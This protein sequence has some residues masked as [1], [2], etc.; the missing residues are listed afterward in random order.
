MRIVPF[1]AGLLFPAAAFAHDY[2]VGDLV[3]VHPMAYETPVTAQSGAGYMKITNNGAQ[4]DRLIAVEA[5]FPRV[6][7]HDTIVEN[8]VSQMVHLDGVDIAPGETVM[9][10]PGGKHVM[11]MGLDGDAFENGE[12]IAAT[13]VFENAGRLDVVFNVE[14]RTDGHGDGHAMDHSGMEHAGHAA[15]M[16]HSGH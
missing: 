6:M 16:D 2:T 4:A 8:D 3:V 12:T 11:F 15:E 13:L 7:V 10:A 1:L 14:E 9:F 5:A